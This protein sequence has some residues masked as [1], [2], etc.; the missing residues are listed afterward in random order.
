MANREVNLTKRVRTSAGIRFCQVVLAANG[1]VKPDTVLVNDKPEIHREGA[2]YLDW[3]DG[4][5]RVRLSVGK[6]PADANNRRLRKEAE[7]NAMAHGAVIASAEKNGR[8]LAA[9]V[10]EYLDDVKVKQT[11]NK[12][13]SFNRHSTFGVYST[14]LNYFMES[15][16]KLTLEAIDRRDLL[17]YAAF[18]Q[19]EKNQGPRSVNHKFGIVMS[20]L[21]AHGIR[22]LVEKNDWPR[23]TQQ[24]PE[25]YEEEELGKLFAACDPVERLW[26]AIR[27]RAR[28]KR[29]L[30]AGRRGPGGE[31]RRGGIRR[32]LRSLPRRSQAGSTQMR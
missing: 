6:D 15:C 1:R 3:R 14:A 17:K 20:F 11:T 23:Y 10:A 31:R 24:E 13:T 26:L 27:T 32:I 29:L 25:I 7:L 21:K 28:T 30:C 22:G 2:Y 8:S 9:A 5:R 16:H 4:A 12:P 19:A 18:L